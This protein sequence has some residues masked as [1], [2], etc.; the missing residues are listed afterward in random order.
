MMR[1]LAVLLLACVGGVSMASAETRKFDFEA[2]VVGEPPKG[3]SFGHTA[4]EGAPGKWVIEMEGTNKLLAQTDPD[5]TRSRFP[6]A[7]VDEI[8]T[9]DVDLSARFKPISGQVDQA[10]GLVWR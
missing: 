1:I 10:A 3:F 7:V 5:S 4:K 9:A 6:V 2:D 8:R